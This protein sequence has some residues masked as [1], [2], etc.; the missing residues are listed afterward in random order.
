MTGAR[1]VGAAAPLIAH[2]AQLPRRSSP[3]RRR[4]RLLLQAARSLPCT[5]LLAPLARAQPAAES[6]LLGACP[7]ALAAAGARAAEAAAG[8]LHELRRELGRRR[9]EARARIG[10]IG[11]GERARVRDTRDT[12]GGAV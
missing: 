7:V 8:D 10:P 6:A 11:G 2:L 12:A 3:L 9:D 1:G 4:I 5:P